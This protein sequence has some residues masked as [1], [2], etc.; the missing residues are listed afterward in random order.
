MLL[1]EFCKIFSIDLFI[2][3]ELLLIWFFLFWGKFLPYSSGCFDKVLLIEFRILFFYL[4]NDDCVESK[5]GSNGLFGFIGMI[6]LLF[7]LSLRLLCCDFFLK[8][9]FFRALL[10]LFTNLFLDG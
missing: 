2:F 10:D 1:I 7:I 3:S 6:L 8:L 4:F 5:E 9:L